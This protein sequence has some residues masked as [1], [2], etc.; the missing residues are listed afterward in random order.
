MDGV[1]PHIRSCKSMAWKVRG[2]RESNS[3]AGAGPVPGGDNSMVKGSLELE[4]LELYDSEGRGGG[5]WALRS[6]SVAGEGPN[7]TRGFL[8][9]VRF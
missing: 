1:H 5:S 7:S 8:G 2:S 3:I 9:L 4:G 6:K